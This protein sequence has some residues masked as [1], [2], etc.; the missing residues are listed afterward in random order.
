MA[1]QYYEGAEA[2]LPENQINYGDLGTNVYLNA[3]LNKAAL[4]NQWEGIA[5]EK[6][7]GELY[8]ELVKQQGE[9]ASDAAS[10]NLKDTIKA[11]VINLGAS[12]VTPMASKIG[13]G[14]SEMF[15]LGED[16]SVLGGPGQTGIN[17][18]GDFTSL[19]R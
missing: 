3:A 14:G 2:F 18:Y 10:Q 15:P 12:I 11:G 6:S 13:G 9:N 19:W 1:R 8:A 5:A 7:A 16:F 4:I 17:N